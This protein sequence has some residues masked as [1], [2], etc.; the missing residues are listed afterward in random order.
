MS[1]H[2]A[3][4]RRHP[5]VPLAKSFALHALASPFPRYF[6][7]SPEDPALDRL[8]HRRRTHPGSARAQLRCA[9]H[10]FPSS[11]DNPRRA[12]W[13]S[14]ARQS[15]QFWPRRK[16][17]QKIPAN[18]AKQ[19]ALAPRACNPRSAAPPPRDQ[20]DSE[21]PHKSASVRFP[22]LPV[23]PDA[24]VRGERR[25]HPRCCTK[26]AARA[27]RRKTREK[28]ARERRPS[29]EDSTL[30]RCSKQARPRARLQGLKPRPSSAAIY[31]MASNHSLPI[32]RR[33][34]LPYCVADFSPSLRMRSCNFLRK[35]TGAFGLKA[36]RYHRGCVRSLLS[37]DKVAA[38]LLGWRAMFSRIAE[39]G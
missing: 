23:F 9:R 26:P 34:R 3:S 33:L 20:P 11:A 38:S 25:I 2:R 10:S 13:D 6:H 31:E 16:T 8:S 5:V 35:F 14:P 22:E 21:G 27:R 12:P 36:T 19:L 4:A 24:R 32:T 17:H 28:R 37:L 7:K 1:R 18:P 30:E 29:C 15:R 39:Y